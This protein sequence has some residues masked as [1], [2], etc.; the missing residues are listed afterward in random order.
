MKN[1]ISIDTIINNDPTLKYFLREVNI[2][3]DLFEHQVDLFSNSG[4]Q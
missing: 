1:T 4:K 3:Y 2:D